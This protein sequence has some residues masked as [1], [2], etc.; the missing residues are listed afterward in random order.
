MFAANEVEASVPLWVGLS[1]ADEE[2]AYWPRLNPGRVFVSVVQ[3]AEVSA[4]VWLALW[5]L[6][7]AFSS[8]GRAPQWV[9]WAGPVVYTD[10]SADPGFSAFRSDRGFNS[11]CQKCCLGTK[12]ITDPYASKSGFSLVVNA[13][14]ALELAS[15][16]VRALEK[17]AIS[18]AQG[19]A[20]LMMGKYPFLAKKLD[21]PRGYYST[22]RKISAGRPA[23]FQAHTW[24]S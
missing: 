6:W 3:C 7:L 12:T 18:H 4:A 19:G 17:N 10:S 16:L 24:L 23:Q 11:Q 21:S 15:A 9:A 14:S 2:G 20:N 13:P 5:D 8:P 22:V 1:V